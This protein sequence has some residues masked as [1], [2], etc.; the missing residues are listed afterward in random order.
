[1]FTLAD[2][3]TASYVAPPPPY[4]GSGVAPSPPA[5]VTVV[6]VDLGVAMLVLAGAIICAAGAC[7]V[8]AALSRRA[9]AADVCHPTSAT[10]RE[11]WA[12]QSESVPP[13]NSGSDGGEALAR[14]AR[15]ASAALSDDARR[16]ALMAACGDGAVPAWQRAVVAIG[17]RGDRGGAPRLVGSA[18]FVDCRSR[19]LC[20]CAHVIDDIAAGARAGATKDPHDAG[21]ALGFGSPA[22]WTHIAFVRSFSPAPAPRDKRNGLDLAILQLV[23]PLPCEERN[24]EWPSP[25]RPPSALAHAPR[26]ASPEWATPAA[27]AAP[28][29]TAVAAARALSALPHSTTTPQEARRAGG[30]ADRIGRS[31]EE[32]SSHGSFSSDSP[33]CSPHSLAS[34]SGT[35]APASPPLAAAVPIGLGGEDQ[36]PLAP[37]QSIAA[38]PIGDEASLSVGDDVVLLGYGQTGRGGPPAA[39]NTR[40]VFCGATEHPVTG[41][42]LRTDALMLAGHSGGPLLNRRGEVIGWSVRSGFDRVHG[43]DGF[44]SS[45][46]NEV[47]PASALIGHVT[48]AL[49][50]MPDTHGLIP[51]GTF[52]LGAAEAR[53]AVMAALAHAFAT[54]G[55]PVPPAAAL[56]PPPT[57]SA[58]G[59]SSLLASIMIRRN[60]SGSSG[61]DESSASR[62]SSFASEFEPPERAT[63]TR[64]IAATSNGT[65]PGR[66]VLGL[67]GWQ[68]P[69]LLRGVR[70]RALEDV[71]TYPDCTH[72][73]AYRV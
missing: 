37:S 25:P 57:S 67:G 40:G 1:M 28:P 71:P 15:A 72:P 35:S 68:L 19:L 11:A 2:V 9:G 55:T 33:C 66:G 30:P 42:W 73:A 10:R 36:D 51:P 58:G 34:S 16:T 4:N 53:E 24:L 38:L 69:P 62:A 14:A 26:G 22:R 41:G 5:S 43:G 18:F 3:A 31:D 60:G 63:A 39:T 20:T 23:A 56:A 70:G 50:R 47:R 13:A 32:K 46:L 17:A 45:G 21:V 6:V 65:A 52:V 64:A 44:Y 8:R 12:T 27:A 59:V 61:T 54:V 49:G 48:G 29:T 7:I